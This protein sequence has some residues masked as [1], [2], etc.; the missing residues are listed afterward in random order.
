MEETP[1]RQE[2]RHSRPPRGDPHKD[3]KD[4]LA[5]FFLSLIQAFLRTGYYTPDHP[6]AEKAT[7][8]LYEGFQELLKDKDELTFLVRSAPEGSS[9]LIE[10]V[11]PEP[12]DLNGLMFQGMAEMYTPKFAKFLERKDL[13]SLTL[14]KKMGKE[15]FTRFVEVMGEP[16]FVDTRERDNKERF[17]LTLKNHG[18]ANISFIFNEEIL[19]TERKMPWRA[20]LAIS[21]LKKDFKMIPL[22]YNLDAEGLKAV[23]CEIIREVAR[24]IH[25]VTVI[26]PL[27][28]NTDLAETE[29]I[30]EAEIE[31]EMIASLPDGLLLR[32]CK[33]FLKQALKNGSAA[34][35]LE[36]WQR[37]A[38]AFAGAL[39]LRQVPGREA[40]LEA[41]FKKKLI[42]LEELSKD[43]QRKIK[44][45][46]FLKKFLRDS[47]TFLNKLDAMHDGETYAKAARYL[48]G[49]IPEF[50][51]RDHYQAALKIISRIDRHAREESDRAPCARE[52]L[53]KIKK[54]K[55]PLALKGK[56]LA[57]D[58][59]MCQAIAPIY[60]LLGEA[61]VPHLLDVLKQTQDPWILKNAFQMLLRIDPPTIDG[62][63][64]ELKGKE[65]AT[66]FAMRII[67]VLGELDLEGSI[68]SAETLK[69]CL[70]HEN[71]HLR[72]EA[73]EAYFKVAGDAGEDLYLELLK[74][75]DIGVQKKAIQ[76]LGRM[77]S[78]QGLEKFLWVLQGGEDLDP[79]KKRQLEASLFSAL[80]FYG[81]IS[82]PD[83]VTLEDFLLDILDRELNPGPLRFFK[84]KESPLSEQAF[85]AIFDSLGKIGTEKS[86]AL[87]EKMGKQQGNIWMKKAADTLKRMEEHSL[88]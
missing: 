84:K 80:G 41:F 49:M 83:D 43:A 68:S 52:V 13:V 58:D 29:E 35:A 75:P 21:R 40:V 81:N 74:D 88:Y 17:A 69:T 78:E 57:A 22:F 42:P 27:L 59:E 54:G 15:E 82:W 6:E 73:L 66:G 87:L 71:P 64:N 50:I 5:Q 4:Q 32:V 77:R 25:D 26:Y 48:R 60:E 86:R 38:K 2:D 19:A 36:K 47:D 56:F 31:K 65:R 51:R 44:V 45:E 61:A 72:E 14:K 79:E 39:K 63:L 33:A 12:Q 8:G 9:I 30:K 3:L 28:M 85:S 7:V 62:I 18:I 55:I 37:L 10:G 53:R 76:C 23:R 67:R 46:A 24:P 1:Q 16:A 34:D 70:R 11:L 20:Q